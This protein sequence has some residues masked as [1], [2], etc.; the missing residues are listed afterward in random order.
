MELSKYVYTFHHL[1]GELNILEDFVSCTP[2]HNN[3]SNRNSNP[4]LIYSSEILPVTP[5]E[6]DNNNNNSHEQ[7]CLNNIHSTINVKEPS[8]D[9]IFKNSRETILYQQYKDTEVKRIFKYIEENDRKF[10]KLML[11][12]TTNLLLCITQFSNYKCLSIVPEILIPSCLRNKCLQIYYLTNYD[13][14]KTCRL[15]CK[16]FYWVSLFTHII[17]FVNSC[18]RCLT[19]KNQRIPKASYQ[20]SLY[21]K[22]T[23]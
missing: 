22:K 20:S 12:K 18:T 23:R 9:P 2:V 5:N 8:P 14:D 17:K 10:D 3:S 6:F 21:T 19:S 13:V 7:E 11:Y 4:K 1:P 15:I 16:K